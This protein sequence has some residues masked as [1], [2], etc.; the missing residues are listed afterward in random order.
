M[1]K[2]ENCRKIMAIMGRMKF[3]K[4]CSTDEEGVRISFYLFIGG[5]RVQNHG[6]ALV[7]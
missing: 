6:H 4:G 5:T 2:N 3:H 1:E 7:M